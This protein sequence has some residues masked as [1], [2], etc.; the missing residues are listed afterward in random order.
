MS[1]F[2]ETLKGDISAD[3]KQRKRAFKARKPCAIC[4]VYKKPSQMMV[5]HIKPVCELTDEEA[6]YDTSNWEVRCIDYEMRLNK[7]KDREKSCAN[8]KS[9]TNHDETKARPIL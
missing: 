4:G 9:N 3:F 2:Y 6:L 8:S 5:A 1:V 7:I